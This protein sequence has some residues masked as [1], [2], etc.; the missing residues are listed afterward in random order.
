MPTKRVA[1]APA[2]GARLAG[3][4]VGEILAFFIFMT[5]TALF[6]RRTYCDAPCPASWTPLLAKDLL[7][8]AEL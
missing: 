3:L 5:A 7:E 8:C 1:V 6:P 2:G 4:A